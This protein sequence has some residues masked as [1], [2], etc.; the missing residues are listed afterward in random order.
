MR[1]QKL[2][3]A[4]WVSLDGMGPKI[5][6]NLCCVFYSGIGVLDTGGH[7][8]INLSPTNAHWRKQC[9]KLYFEPLDST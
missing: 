4:N 9:K 3:L 2:W 7:V 1:N 8:T 5:P 6:N